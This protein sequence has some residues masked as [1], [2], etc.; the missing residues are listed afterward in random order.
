MEFYGRNAELEALES[1]YKTD[2][3]AFFVVY[4]RRRIGK[5]TLLHKFIENKKALYFSAQEANETLNL[6]KFSQELY[7]LNNIKASMPAFPSWD[8][9]FSYLSEYVR[10]HK[11]VLVIDEFPYIAASDKSI[12]SLLQHNIDLNWKDTNLFLI[13]CG[14][15]MSFMQNEVLSYKS[16]LFGRRTAQIHLKPFC[17]MKVVN[18][19]IH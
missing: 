17:F 14:S 12:L 5:T 15:S 7:Q 6:I 11:L 4:G 8:S 1:S 9:A 3:F 18:C 10:E 19:C 16:P 13:L 2:K